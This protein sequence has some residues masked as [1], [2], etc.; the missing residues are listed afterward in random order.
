MMEKILW[1][2]VAA[3]GGGAVWL[4]RSLFLARPRLVVRY[5][6]R[7][8]QS[9]AGSAGQL[10]VRWGYRVII[11]NVSKND[12][13]EISVVRSTNPQLQTLPA[14]HLKGLDELRL[15]PNL[16]TELDRDVVVNAQHDFHGRLEPPELKAL[17][18]VLRY[19]SESG[20]AH[21]TTYERVGGVDSNKHSLRAPEWAAQR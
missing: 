4:V 17:T 8:G 1:S 18:L 3:I 19:K 21:Y 2:S 9:S 13:L 7:D 5:E 14:N 6:H 11:T 15:E 16:V 20:F 10:R 12:A